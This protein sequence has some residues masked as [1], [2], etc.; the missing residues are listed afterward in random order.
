[1]TSA[2][3]AASGDVVLAH[4][5][6]VVAVPAFVPALVIVGAVIWVARRDRRAEAAEQAA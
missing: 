1:M 5:A 4:H 3:L 6:L 2:A